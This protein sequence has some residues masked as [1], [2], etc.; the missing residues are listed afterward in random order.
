MNS[1]VQKALAGVTFGTAQT[2]GQT[3][4]LPLVRQEDL[5]P[6]YLTLSE[7]LTKELVTVTEVSESGS[8]PEL[9]VK[10][11][12]ELPVLILDGEELRGA[13]QNRVCNTTILLCEKRETVIPVSC[14]EQGRWSYQTSKFEDSHLVMARKARVNKSRSVSAGVKRFAAVASASAEH[15]RS[16]QGRVWDDVHRLH[17]DLAVA[18]PTGAMRDAYEAH[19]HRLRETAK[20]FP[21]VEGQC[22]LLVAHNGRVLGLDLVSRPSAYRYLH[23]RLLKSYVIDLRDTGDD[24]PYGTMENWAPWFIESLNGL[25]ESAHPSVGHGT[26]FRFEGPTTCGSALVY[27]DTGIH[28]AFFADQIEPDD[29]YWM[30]R[31]RARARRVWRRE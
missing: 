3:S 4:V 6:A 16:D 28:A 15:Y 22:G 26:D 13:K 19:G 10:N 21:C 8:V 1:A 20:A 18:S 31:D 7:A 25:T 11:D 30:V 14:T 5:E 27:E 24:V 17:E 12:A 29:R 23:E 2:L 9:R